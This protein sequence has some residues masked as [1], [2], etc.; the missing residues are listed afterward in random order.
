M[1]VKSDEVRFE[2]AGDGSGVDDLAWGQQEIWLAMVRQRSW[3]PIGGP[4]RLKAGTTLD[5]VVDD[6]QYTL[7]RYQTM[8]TRLRFSDDGRVRQEVSARGEFVIEVFD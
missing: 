4:G 7:G 5:D 8:R 1:F 6:L 2:F 3:I